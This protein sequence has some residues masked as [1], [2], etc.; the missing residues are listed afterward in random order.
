[1]ETVGDGT[2]TMLADTKTDVG[3]FVI[4]KTG[5]L[6]LEIDHGL[7]AS[8]VRAGQVG[9]ATNEFGDDRDDR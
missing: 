3:T 5:A 1:M 6:G 9:R 8:E 7:R 4:T 2:H